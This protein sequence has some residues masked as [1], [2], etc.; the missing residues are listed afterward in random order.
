ML[1][2]LSPKTNIILNTKRSIKYHWTGS[3]S[4]IWLN[5]PCGMYITQITNTF[6]C[7]SVEFYINAPSCFSTSLQL[8]AQHFFVQWAEVTKKGVKMYK[9]FKKRSIYQ[10]VSVHV[11]AF[12]LIMSLP[13][14]CGP[15]P[16]LRS[17]EAVT[18]LC[19]GRVW[20]RSVYCEKST[21]ELVNL[22]S[23]TAPCRSLCLECH[24]SRGGERALLRRYKAP[25]FPPSLRAVQGETAIHQPVE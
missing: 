4:K 14:K 16:T 25:T 7:T 23:H 11:W 24:P 8:K 19:R 10:G 5:E 13:A 1:K 3:S 17:T 18:P 12:S 6:D 9:R 21:Q 15:P 22:P 2:I 20:Q